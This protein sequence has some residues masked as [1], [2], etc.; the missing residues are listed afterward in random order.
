MRVSTFERKTI[1]L[2]KRK[3]RGEEED[4]QF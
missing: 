1:Y 3:G 4:K 2:E